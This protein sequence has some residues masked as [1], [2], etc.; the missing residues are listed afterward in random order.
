[1]ARSAAS[2]WFCRNLEMSMMDA[3]IKE[4][5]ILSESE[6]PDLF[7]GLARFKEENV[8]KVNRK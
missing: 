4:F 7:K 1:M 5:Q 6:I 3:T 2:L 8:E